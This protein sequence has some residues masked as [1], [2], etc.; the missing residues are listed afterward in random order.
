I[1]SQAN[2][3]HNEFENS[4]EELSKNEVGEIASQEAFRDLFLPVI[5]INCNGIS[6]RC[7]L[8]TLSIPDFAFEQA[9][10]LHLELQFEH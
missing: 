3:S 1:I 10:N 8:E 9:A 7:P 4:E 5:S 6:K 2:V